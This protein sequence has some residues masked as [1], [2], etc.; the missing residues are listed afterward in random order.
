[1]YLQEHFVPNIMAMAWTTRTTPEAS[2]DREPLR[3]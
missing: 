3:Y 2:R 1:M